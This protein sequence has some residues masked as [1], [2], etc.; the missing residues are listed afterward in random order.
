MDLGGSARCNWRGCTVQL[1][2]VHLAI[3][4]GAPCIYIGGGGGGGIYIGRKG[5]VYNLWEGSERRS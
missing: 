2:G 4:R 5:G 1:E 3:G